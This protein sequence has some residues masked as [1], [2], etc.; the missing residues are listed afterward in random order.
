MNKQLYFDTK[1]PQ[2]ESEKIVFLRNSWIGKESL[3]NVITNTGQ[4]TDQLGMW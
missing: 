3:F 2:S 4:P 1:M